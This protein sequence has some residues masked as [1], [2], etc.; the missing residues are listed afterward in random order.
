MI[1]LYAGTATTVASGTDT[2]RAI[3]SGN[4]RMAWYLVPLLV[5]LALGATVFLG[6]IVYCMLRGKHLAATFNR[7]GGIFLIGC[8]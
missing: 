2:L 8:A 7:G 4:Y 1:A 3:R 6:A 5:L